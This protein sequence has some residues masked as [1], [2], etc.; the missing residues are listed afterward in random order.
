MEKKIV[1]VGNIECGGDEL[2]LISGPCVIE[3][4]KIMME[5]AEKLKGIS[6]RLKIK[7]IYNIDISHVS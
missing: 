4:E 2:F 3:E 7:I 1:R 6:E 5:T